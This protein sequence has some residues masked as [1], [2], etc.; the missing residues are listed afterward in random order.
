MPAMAGRAVSSPTSRMCR[1]LCGASIHSRPGRRHRPGWGRPSAAGHPCGRWSPRP[2]PGRS[3]HAGRSPHPLRRLRGA[4]REWCRCASAACPAVP[5]GGVPVAT[6]RPWAGWAQ[7]L[8]GGEEQLDA[9]VGSQGGHPGHVRAA[10]DKR[11]SEGSGPR[12]P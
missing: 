12:W 3:P 6:G 1:A 8:R 4:G 2:M 5:G 10:E 7:R 9:L 11:H